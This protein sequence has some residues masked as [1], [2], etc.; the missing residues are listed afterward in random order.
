MLLSGEVTITFYA[1]ANVSDLTLCHTPL[2]SDRDVSIFDLELC[3]YTMSNWLL[4]VMNLYRYY[5]LIIA[6]V[7]YSDTS[8]QV[9]NYNLK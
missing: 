7:P 4:I 2:L 5:R 6:H 1:M 3:V 9:F 8:L